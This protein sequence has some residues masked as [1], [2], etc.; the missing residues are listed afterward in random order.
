MLAEQQHEIVERI[1]WGGCSPVAE[2]SA[3]VFYSRNTHVSTNKSPQYKK[4]INLLESSQR[5]AMQVAKGLEGKSHGRT[6]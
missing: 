2:I 3:L 4:A 5:K 6:D 1:G